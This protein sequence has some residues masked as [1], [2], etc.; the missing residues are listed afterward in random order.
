[1]ATK[2]DLP[3]RENC[4]TFTAPEGDVSLDDLI[5]AIELTAGEDSVLVLQHMG[6]AKF[7]VCTRN[8]CQATKLMV[9]EGFRVNGEVVPVEAVGPPV[10]YVNAYRY[11]AYLP[12]E[13]LS[14]ALA[15]VRQGEGHHLCHRGHPPK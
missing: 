10:T 4:F 8:A 5:D 1:M 7:L 13:T 14:N 12:D 2:A 9:A 3:V 6:G 11:P 15:P